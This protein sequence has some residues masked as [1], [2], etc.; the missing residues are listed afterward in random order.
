VDYRVVCGR[1]VCELGVVNVK[2]KIAKSR[3]LGLF[4]PGTPITVTSMWQHVDGNVWR[5]VNIP[6]RMWGTRT[7][8]KQRSR[9]V[10]LDTG[11]HV[12]VM[13]AEAV[14]YY[15]TRQKPDVYDGPFVKIVWSNMAIEYDIGG[16]YGAEYVGDDAG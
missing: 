5:E 3:A 11:S 9:D 10:I 7:V 14:W 6:L 13:N 15:E 12:D 16:D 8:E 4:T 2:Q 1:T